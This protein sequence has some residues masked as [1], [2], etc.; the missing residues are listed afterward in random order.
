[1]RIVSVAVMAFV[2]LTACGKNQFSE[3]TELVKEAVS[4]DKAYVEEMNKA[5]RPEEMVKAMENYQNHLEGLAPQWEKVFA[6]LKTLEGNGSLKAKMDA[7]QLI[8]ASGEYMVTQL[9]VWEKTQASLEKYP[10]DEGVR[11]A[12]EK[13]TATLTRWFKEDEKEKH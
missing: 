5:Q 13:V 12:A 3:T 11:A 6:Q 8:L 7:G 10:E 1:M 9:S 2:L 4:M